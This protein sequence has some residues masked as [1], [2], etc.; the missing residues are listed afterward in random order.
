MPYGR[1]CADWALLD[2]GVKLRRTEYGYDAACTRI[3]AESGYP[4]AARWADYFVRAK[5]SD[6]QALT[7]FGPV[8]ARQADVHACGDPTKAE[9]AGPSDPHNV[10][11]QRPSS[12][13]PPARGSPPACL[14]QVELG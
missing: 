14:G 7:L 3:D 6:R 12:R 5:A 8:T 4:D 10:R 1:P 9:P 13:Q 2:R 11:S